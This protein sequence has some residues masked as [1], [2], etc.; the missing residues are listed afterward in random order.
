MRLFRLVVRLRLVT[1]RVARYNV[2]MK[3]AALLLLLAGLLAL[4]GCTTPAA[5][6]KRYKTSYSSFDQPSD[7]ATKVVTP[8]GSNV[9]PAG[10]DVVPAGCINFIGA[11]VS[12]VLEIYAQVANRTLL[13]GRL[14]GVQIVC[15]T[16]NR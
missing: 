13:R 6:A 3:S 12:Q 8:A 9:V 11:D 10:N 5:A 1:P 4:T 14:P 7:H 16:I 2:A 15:K